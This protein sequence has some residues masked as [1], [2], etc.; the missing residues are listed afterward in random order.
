MDS[1]KEI[2]R[3]ILSASVSRWD[4]IYRRDSKHRCSSCI[5]I[6]SSYRCF[7]HLRLSLKWSVIKNHI[8]LHN[9]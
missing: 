3:L 7:F 8:V 6:N 1:F 5:S 2:V 9:S 4:R